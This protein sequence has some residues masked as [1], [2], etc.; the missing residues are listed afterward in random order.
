MAEESKAGCSCGIFNSFGCEPI[1]CAWTR[2]AA[3]M[4][5]R[6]SEGSSVVTKHSVENLPNREHRA[7][8]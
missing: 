3:G 5:V 7:V 4:I 1:L 6:D 2:V 8:C